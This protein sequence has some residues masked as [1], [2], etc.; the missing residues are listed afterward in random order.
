MLPLELSTCSGMHHFP[1]EAGI[2]V[3]AGARPV[4][5]SFKQLFRD[6]E[7]YRAEG[8]DRTR[9]TKWLADKHEWYAPIDY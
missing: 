9:K 4:I 2:S 8:R 3:N 6:R 1:T 7:K 5:D